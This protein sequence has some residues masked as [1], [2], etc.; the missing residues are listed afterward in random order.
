MARKSGTLGH[1]LLGSALGALLGLVL[2]AIGLALILNAMEARPAPGATASPA[3]GEVA[4]PSA[5][6][7]VGPGTS[8]QAAYPALEAGPGLVVP[9]QAPEPLPPQ[10]RSTWRS[11]FED[12]PVAA[13]PVPAEA[14]LAPS[15]PPTATAPQAR[16]PATPRAAPQAT[17]QED[18]LFY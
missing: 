5:P 7:E 13:A 1:I 14:A 4:P 15:A 8:T 9:P 16:R 17:T 6:A 3:S 10:S 11:I 12:D 2:L 18:S